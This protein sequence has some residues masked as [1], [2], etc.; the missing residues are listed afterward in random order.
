M[1]GSLWM[2]IVVLI[3]IL[4]GYWLMVHLFLSI[5]FGYNAC[6]PPT[7]NQ[8]AF[9]ILLC[10]IVHYVIFSHAY[11]FPLLKV[12]KV[13]LFAFYK[14]LISLACYLRLLIFFNT[15]FA[16]LITFCT[17]LITSSTLW[18]IPPP[19]PLVCITSS[20]NL[21]VMNKPRYSFFSSA[22]I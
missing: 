8:S 21:W 14:N 2:E 16:Y 4:Y 12:I 17:F 7:S 18:T 20:E 11:N 10:M 22:M 3:L 5:T 6:L 15:F 13:Y 9:S 19:F 1:K